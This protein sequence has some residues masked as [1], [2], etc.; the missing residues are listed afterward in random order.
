MIGDAAELMAKVDLILKG[1]IVLSPSSPTSI[2]DLI[3]D[4]GDGKMET[5]QVKAVDK[6]SKAFNTY[7][8]SGA[9]YRNGK[10]RPTLYYKNHN[11]DWMIGV[12]V[13]EGDIFYYPLDTYQNYDRI[14][15]KTVGSLPFRFN[16]NVKSPMDGPTEGSLEEELTK[17][18]PLP[19]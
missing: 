10:Q 5:A 17:V 14:A 9:T 1:W 12:D 18:K 19:Y 15:T 3:I 6:K 7:S 16:H 4:V 8:T 11:I 13:I 2:Y